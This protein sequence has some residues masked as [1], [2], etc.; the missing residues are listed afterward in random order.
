MSLFPLRLD[1]V[2]FRPNGRD[3]LDGVDLTLT[4][5]G[6]TIVLGPNGAG[7]S[8]LLRT[9]CGLLSPTGGAI[10]YGGEPFDGMQVGMVFQH[11]MML[12]SSVLENVTL[13]LR[14][15]G[16]GRAERQACGIA[17]LERIGLADRMHDNARRLSG[18]EQQRLALGRVWLTRPRLL[19]LDEPT[20]SLDPS[21]VEA[22]ER[23]VREIRTEGAKIVMT[24]HNLGQATRLA[25]DI[26]FLAEGKVREHT[27]VRGFFTHPASEEA[28]R[29]IEGELPWHV[30]F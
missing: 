8:V 19:L 11:P 23:I 4:G 22:V 18:G 27:A 3:V 26:V 29:F 1:Q 2:R 6:I 10:D 28:K 15:R 24:T 30:T 25:D 9:I 21:A 12:R 7:K 20:A 14:P 17:M 16:I 5:E 13:G